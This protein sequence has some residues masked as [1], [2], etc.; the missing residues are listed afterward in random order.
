MKLRLPAFALITAFTVI[1]C[2][3]PPP[4]PDDHFYRL[5]TSAI[6]HR[7]DQ[8]LI[9]A[10]LYVERPRAAGARRGRKML[11]SDDPGHLRFQ[12]YHYHHWEDAVPELLHR[13]LADQLRDSGVADRIGVRPD[14]TAA[15]RLESR[16]G[17]FERLIDGGSYAV[18][19]ELE[20][21]LTP[22]SKPQRTLFE[23][24]YSE[25]V[26]VSSSMDDTVKGFSAALD[27]TMDRLLADLENLDF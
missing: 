7:F 16:V 21:R 9:S 19:V 14:G 3:T 10:G 13:R 5:A 8:P 17:R 1:A 15:F 24:V 4:V 23:D 18:V 22:G 2:G 20:F 12:Q 27:R 25:T 26:D 11:Y 6:S